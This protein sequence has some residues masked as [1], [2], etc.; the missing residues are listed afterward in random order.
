ME[1]KCHSFNII[2]YA[3]P[4]RKQSPHLI[5][6]ILYICIVQISIQDY[7]E[8][9]NHSSS[10]FRAYSLART[11]YCSVA[12]AFYINNIEITFSRWL[13]CPDLH[14]GF[15]NFCWS[16]LFGQ[17][18]HRWP[19]VNNSFDMETVIWTLSKSRFLPGE[20]SPSLFIA[21]CFSLPIKAVQLLHQKL[22]LSAVDNADISQLLPREKIQY[23]DPDL[24][25]V[26]LQKNIFV[27]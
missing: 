12:I 4:F 22:S 23:N 25:F 21:G 5:Q 24:L 14:Q 11:S 13:C 6:N 15:I 19:N 17:E 16:T 9:D 3:M 26:F 27:A 8:Q 1:L 10:A 7:V 2:L 18:P 20:H